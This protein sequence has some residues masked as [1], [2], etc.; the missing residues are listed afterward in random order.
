MNIN[1]QS[2]LIIRINLIFLRVSLTL[3]IDSSLLDNIMNPSKN[4]REGQLRRAM[5]NK[6]Q[7]SHQIRA[8]VTQQ[9][10]SL[11]KKG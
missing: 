5:N 3:F 8:I 4:K 11:N 1:K 10:P 9:S 7:R 2:I 6:T